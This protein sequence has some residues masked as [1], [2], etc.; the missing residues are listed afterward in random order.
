MLKVKQLSKIYQG[1]VPTRALSKINLTIE[2]GEFVGI[3]GP[4]GSG[5][6]TLLNMVSTIDTP[7]SGEILINGQNPHR[8]KKTSWRVSVAATWGLSFRI[9]ICWTR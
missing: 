6:T 5:K 2:K 3:M 1:K 4:S 7:S 9:L 8:M